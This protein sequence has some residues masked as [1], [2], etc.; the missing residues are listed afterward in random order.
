M[1]APE[2]ATGPDGPL[3]LTTKELAE[4]FRTAPSSIRDWRSKGFG[5]L[6]I[7][8]GRNVLYPLPEVEK[9]EQRQYE[10]AQRQHRRNAAGIHS[11]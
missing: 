10:A 9:W 3:Y 4:R 2:Y 1:T 8:F 5:P 6:G 7:R 11:T